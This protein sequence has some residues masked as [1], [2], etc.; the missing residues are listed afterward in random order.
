[1][2]VKQEKWHCI[3]DYSSEDLCIPSFC[4]NDTDYSFGIKLSGLCLILLWLWSIK[5]YP[6]LSQ[7]WN[8]C[9][10]VMDIVLLQIPFYR[11][12]VT[13]TWANHPFACLKWFVFICMNWTVQF[14][15]YWIL[16]K[17]PQSKVLSCPPISPISIITIYL[18]NNMVWSILVCNNY[19]QYIES[20]MLFRS[21]SVSPKI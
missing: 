18:S 4:V 5:F 20:S 2:C 3:F 7:R 14:P 1:M 19:L 9:W 6:W 21:F 16:Q 11:Q 17:V 13:G 8:A 12:L 10:S 15:N